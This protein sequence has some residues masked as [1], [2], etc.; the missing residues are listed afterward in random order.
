MTD[1]NVA[2]A[3]VSQ[4][5][6][7]Q[8]AARTPLWFY[9]ALL[10]AVLAVFAPPATARDAERGDA[11][12]E[13]VPDLEAIQRGF[14]RVIERVTPSVVG[15]RVQRRH[16]TVLSGSD[17]AGGAGTFEQ[18][19]IVNGTGTVLRADGLIL[20]NEHVIQ[21]ADNIQVLFHDGQTLP[22]TVVAADT[23]GDLAVLRVARR[24]LVPARL[25]DWS[26]VARGQWSIVLGNPY[27][28]GRDGKL[29]AS[30]GV[31]SNLG[32]RL[33]GLGETD[34]RFYDDMIQ[35]TAAICPGNSG[36][37][38]FNIRGELI[39][40]V[41]AMHTRAAASE[42]I[43]FAIP[44]NSAKRGL[45]ERLIAGEAI[46][47]G[48]LGITARPP[49]AAERQAA[50]LASDAGA[51]V[52][53]I[54]PGGPGARAALREGDVILEYNGQRVKNPAHLVELVGQ[55]PAGRQVVLD[56]RR[57]RQP[58]TLRAAIDRRQR[59]RVGGLLRQRDTRMAS[60]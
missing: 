16:V 41:T 4:N 33:P 25:G 15:L 54:E 49:A 17:A 2:G 44:L 55:T 45:V 14:Q 18:T 57:G 42:G 56:V 51:V 12:T 3:R 40:V 36:G 27:G 19:V 1:F 9:A 29:C 37:P 8:V 46:A 31:I 32:R 53:T 59:E 23:R 5:R 35:T 6:L 30:V 28:L 22:A 48:Y 52:E 13:A 58:L 11:A 38:L 26:E 39:G 34:D 7:L 20:T 60:P 10:F 21:S 43:C 47:Y 50:G 24:D